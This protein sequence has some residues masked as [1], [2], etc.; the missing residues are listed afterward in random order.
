MEHIM[1]FKKYITGI[2]V[3]L[4]MNIYVNSLLFKKADML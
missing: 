3:F 2:R 1:I 4:S